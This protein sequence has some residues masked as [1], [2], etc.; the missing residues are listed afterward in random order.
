MKLPDLLSD[1]LFRL[2]VQKGRIP[3]VNVLT[4]KYEAYITLLKRLKSYDKFTKTIKEQIPQIQFLCDG[5]VNVITHYL[6][7]KPHKAYSEFDKAMSKVNNFVFHSIRERIKYPEQINLFR[8]RESGSRYLKKQDIFHVPFELRG[9]VRNQ[10][11][12]I[13]GYPCLYFGPSVYVCWEELNRPNFENVFISKFRLLRHSAKLLDLTF[14]VSQA[15]QILNNSKDI[16]DFYDYQVSKIV[17]KI[18]LFP[19]IISCSLIEKESTD[20]FKEEYVIPQILLEW[21]RDTSEIDAIQY[22]S[23]SLPDYDLSDSL[24]T[25]YVFPAKHHE[26]IG[27]C[28]HLANIFEFTDPISWNFAKCINGHKKTVNLN[29][30]LDFNI[31][32]QKRS[33]QH[34][35]FGHMEQILDT[36][37]L[38]KLAEIYHA[39][40]PV[41]L[42]SG[43]ATR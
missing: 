43:A 19:L 26:H 10:R 34:T 14:S 3:S 8:I 6:D 5:L 4:E 37:I 27:F 17:D 35:E 30:R 16:D 13:N 20:L 33:Y 42:V 39:T 23:M 7:G 24:F 11:F 31:M 1:D 21:V 40:T 41:E 32:N 28:S 22:S 29:S 18:I 12:S 9:M 15:K 38:R 25:N 36:M 2:P